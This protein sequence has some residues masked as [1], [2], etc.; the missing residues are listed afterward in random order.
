MSGSREPRDTLGSPE[1]QGTITA[2]VDVHQ[3]LIRF[4]ELKKTFSQTQEVLTRVAQYSQPICEAQIACNH[5]NQIIDL[6]RQIKELQTKQFLP[7]QCVHTP[8]EQQIQTLTNEWDEGRRR[9]TAPRTDEEFR[10]PFAGMTE[11]VEQSGKEVRRLR[12]QLA[13]LL[14]L[15]ARAA[16]AA[17]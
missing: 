13:N 11:D 6:Q 15:S 1:D 12:M 4:E 5:P 7:P 10:K 14:T 16:S 2:V 9:P 8:F 3:D 17:P